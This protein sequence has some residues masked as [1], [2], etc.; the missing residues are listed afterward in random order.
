MK[1]LQVINTKEMELVDIETPSPCKD[2]VLI[3]V[4]YCGV[5]G[6]DLARYFKG[7]VH[8][9]PQIL[10]HEFS[11]I[12]E[13]VG[14]SVKSI[15]VGDR[16]AVAPLKPCGKC[17]MCETGEPA[18]C[19]NY[20]FIG[21]REPGA[22]AEYVV[23]PERNVMVIP[24]ELSL[25]EAA[26]VEPLTVAIHGVDRLKVESGDVALVLGSGTIG[27]LTI[28][29]LRAKGV[30]KIIATDLSE[31]KLKYAKNMGADVAIDTTE[32]TLDDYFKDQQ[33][34]DLVYE[35]AGSPYTHVEAFKFVR[36]KGQVCYI[37]TSTSEITFNHKEF[38]LINRGELTV[39]GSWMSYS[40][41]FPG[42]EW[43]AA[44]N[45]L[46]NKEIMVKDLIT[47]VH[48]LEDK[49]LPFNRLIDKDIV[50]VDEIYEIS[51]EEE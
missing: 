48:S 50:A 44:L 15:E 34:P 10:G 43:G 27:L 22:M 16:V 25:K 37:G 33:L 13:S 19:T 1:A 42:K 21:S 23:A 9:F 41:P 24:D 3:K 32:V 6:S 38:E 14:D 40:A 51:K 11:G 31:E 2:E 28:G 35:T 46:A 30:K 45:Y 8:K 47:G 20:S 17:H 7:Q 12:I 29:V 18:M 39:T 49:S 4:A 36:K 5:C 26:L